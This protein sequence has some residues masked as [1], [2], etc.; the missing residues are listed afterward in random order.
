[1]STFE[2]LLVYLIICV[3]EVAERNFAVCRLQRLLAEL[4]RLFAEACLRSL[5][6][7]ATRKIAKVDL[8]RPS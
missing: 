6:F 4:Q 5:N 8:R 2:D 1:M 7:I 3:S